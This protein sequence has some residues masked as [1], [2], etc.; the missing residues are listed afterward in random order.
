MKKNSYLKC[1]TS[2]VYNYIIYFYAEKVCTIEAENKASSTWKVVFIKNN[3]FPFIAK[4]G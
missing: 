2:S 1:F 4:E 3:V